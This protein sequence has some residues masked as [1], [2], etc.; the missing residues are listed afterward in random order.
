MKK[1]LLNVI[2]NLI[3][4]RHRAKG[5]LITL[6]LAFGSLLDIAS[7]ASFFPIL[8]L[9][10]NQDQSEAHWLISNIYQVI[11]FE[12]PVTLGIALVLVVVFL[13]IFKTVY[14]IWITHLKARF[15]Y[16][17]SNELA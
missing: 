5:L 12:S 2:T 4:Q 9:I 11:K 15:A 1:N 14:Q 16:E 8:I 6:G 7:L 13:S 17:V 3:A 10:V